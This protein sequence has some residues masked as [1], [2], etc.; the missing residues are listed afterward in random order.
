PEVIREVKSHKDESILDQISLDLSQ[1]LFERKFGSIVPWKEEVNRLLETLQKRTN[2]NV[3]MLGP[4]GVGKRTMVMRLAEQIAAG[5]VPSRLR[6]KKIL[7]IGL[8]SVLPLIQDSEEFEKILFLAVKEALDRKDVIL[9]FNQL[10]NFIGT[11]EGG[12]LD[13]SYLLDAATRQRDLQVIASM[14]DWAYRKVVNENSWIRYNMAS[15]T[16]QEPSRNMAKKILRVV[17]AKLEK[18]HGLE[19]TA[20][21]VDRAIDLSNYYLKTRVLPGKALEILDEACAEVVIR[22]MRS[23]TAGGPVVDGK[24]VE[25]TLSSRLGI[26]IEKLHHRAGSSLLLL[27]DRL[28]QRVKGQ[29]RAIQQVADVIRVAKQ[30]LSAKPQRPDGVFFFVGPNGVGKNEL[31]RSLALELFGSE[32]HLIRLDMTQFTEDDAAMKLIGGRGPGETK[33]ILPRILA[34]RPNA[35]FVIEGIEKANSKIGPI[36]LQILN[37]GQVVDGE[38]RMLSF[39]ST[40]M[41]VVANSDNLLGEEE[42]T[43]GFTEAAEANRIENQR[44]AIESGTRNFFGTEFLMSFDE[45]VFFDPLTPDSICEIT[46]LQVAHI[47]ERLYERGIILTVP[48]EVIQ[49]VAD[50]GGSKSGGASHLARLVESHILQPISRYLLKHPNARKVRVA[51]KKKHVVVSGVRDKKKPAPSSRKK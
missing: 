14:S 22:N 30:N 13:A 8:Q 45:L 40:T 29:D 21:A 43:V 4:T 38:G 51:L 17:R 34:N 42:K 5:R 11:A 20:E 6:N 44:K 27:E 26:P 3:L 19:I 12:F 10:D 36:L 50:E 15:V 48:H 23:R 49:F 9:Y 31:A 39:A 2:H 16:I 24:A 35:V 32:E 37:D 47:E 18:F 28:G 1:S 46:E 41:V 33:G 7:E 25:R